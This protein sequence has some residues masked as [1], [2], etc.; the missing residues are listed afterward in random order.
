MR[1]LMV[2]AAL[3]V[4]DTDTSDLR[5]ENVAAKSEPADSK[6]SPAVEKSRYQ[7]A[8]ANCVQMWDRGTHMT[9]QQWLRACRRV[10]DRL[11]DL[12]FQ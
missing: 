8:V 12:S 3:L 10:Q 6:P 7:G 4:F 5:A 2:V 11:R 9:Q 1:F